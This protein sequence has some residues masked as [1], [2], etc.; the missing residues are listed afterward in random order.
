MTKE[1]LGRDLVHWHVADIAYVRDEDK[2]RELLA[3][4][5]FSG[6]R[7]FH[8]RQTGTDALLAR[9][10][11]GAV[12]AFR[13]TEK[14]H[15]DILTDLRFR[16]RDKGVFR[17]HRGFDAS[18]LSVRDEVCPRVRALMRH[19]VRVA[20]TGHSLGGAVALRAAAGLGL[21][22]VVTFGAPGSA[23]A[24]SRPMP[25]QRPTTAA[26]CAAPTSFLWCRC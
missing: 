15:Q 26:M 24:P 14:N 2:A 5:G 13:G 10:G 18:W 23:T 3:Q 8:D 4:R 9:N 12:L 20:A 21:G 17:V 22:E 6:A 1:R 11:D 19:G 7:F 16:F 25:G